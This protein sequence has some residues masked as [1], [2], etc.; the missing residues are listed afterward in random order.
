MTVD[1]SGKAVLGVMKIRDGLPAGVDESNA[2]AFRRSAFIETQRWLPLNML[3]TFDQPVMNPNCD[4]RRH[5]TVSTQAL[6]FMNDAMIVGFAQGLADQILSA[7]HDRTDQIVQLFETLFSV[8]PSDRELRDCRDYLDRQMKTFQA[9]EIPQDRVEL[10]AMATL[11]QT[12]LAS[13][14]FL[15]VD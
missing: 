1:S 8:R 2:D 5:S 11:C 4:L 15:Y 6:W 3:S 13:N 7:T 9:A 14:R 10:T 12:M